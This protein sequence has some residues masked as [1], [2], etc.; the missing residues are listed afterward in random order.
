M[1]ILNLALTFQVVGDVIIALV[2]FSVHQHIRKE[3][4]IDRDVLG[5]LKRERVYIAFGIF[6]IIV[7]YLIEIAFRGG[8]L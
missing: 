3:H 4:R 2:V 5:A 1:N 8:V 6:S 7:G